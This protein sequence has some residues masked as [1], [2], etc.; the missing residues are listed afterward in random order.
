MAW[1]VHTWP[2]LTW[3][4]PAWPVQTWLVLTLPV[5]TYL[6][7][8]Y[9]FRLD[10][11]Q[12][13][14]SWLVL[15]GLDLSRHDLSRFGLT[16]PELTCPELTFSYMT[17]PNLTFSNFTY[18]CPGLL[19]IEHLPSRPKKGQKNR[20]KYQKEIMKSCIYLWWVG[21]VSNRI[22][23]NQIITGI[24]FRMHK[25]PAFLIPRC[26]MKSIPVNSFEYWYERQC[27]SQLLLGKQLPK[28]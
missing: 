16:R 13:D 10:L 23:A 5:L 14:L 25:W 17:C 12:L 22:Y 26:L 18:P 3:P 21:K 6:S 24:V 19:T 4:V 28:T 27:C 20:Q 9:L 15:W 7:R 2:A 11:S 1:P 8:I